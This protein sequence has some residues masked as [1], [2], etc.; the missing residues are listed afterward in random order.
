MAVGT[1]AHAIYI[2]HAALAIRVLAHEVHRGQIQLP[3]A[4]VARLLVVEVDC[5]L[6][7]LRDLLLAVPD[8]GHF[9]VFAPVLLV[10]SDLLRA[11]IFEQEG[12]DNAE[13]QFRVGFEDF[14]HQE[15][16]Q[17]IFQPNLFQSLLK[18]LLCIRLESTVLVDLVS[19]VGQSLNPHVAV[20]WLVLQDESLALANFE[21]F[22][23]SLLLDVEVEQLVLQ[24]FVRLAAPHD[25]IFRSVD[26]EQ[27]EHVVLINLAAVIA[28]NELVDLL[29]DLLQLGQFQHGRVVEGHT[30]LL[31]AQDRRIDPLLLDE[32]ALEQPVVEL[33]LSESLQV[34]EP[35]IA[36]LVQNALQE[37]GHQIVVVDEYLQQVFD[38][39]HLLRAQLEVL[40]NLTSEVVAVSRVV[41]HGFHDSEG[42]VADI[43]QRDC[44][45]LASLNEADRSSVL[46]VSLLLLAL[47]EQLG[48]VHLE[49][50]DFF[51]HVVDVLVN[52]DQRLLVLV[53]TL[54]VNLHQQ[55]PPLLLLGQL[56]CMLSGRVLLSTNFDGRVD[57]EDRCL[58]ALLDRQ[59]LLD[60][61]LLVFLDIAVEQQ[62]C[63]VFLVVDV[64]LAASLRRLVIANE[65][66]Q[67][68]DQVVK[69]GDL[70]V[71]LDDVAGVQ[72]ADSLDVLLNRIIVLL[73]LEKFV[74]V[75]LDDL[76]L[77]LGREVCLLRDRLG[78]CI[79]RLLHQ[80][81]NLHVVL[82]RVQLDQLTSRH[83]LRLVVRLCDVIDALLAL[84]L[85]DL[86]VNDGSVGRR[87]PEHRDLV[88]EVVD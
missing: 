4:V 45:V 41:N 6:L 27:E 83:L 66:L 32:Q 18:V 20:D 51:S 49:Q 33:D 74:G 73:L 61:S 68:S 30:R 71:V 86:D 65:F 16:R 54:D 35:S 5:C 56:N 63:V 80:V 11:Q 77:D 76:A 10:D 2:L 84:R 25:A 57:I 21:H 22:R 15:G 85:F 75:L 78:L 67:V 36:E 23:S 1:L 88:L 24:V 44:A 72:E 3:L 40:V 28:L 34:I 87:A 9:L 53:L 39:D 58:V 38:S 46:F 12:L 29:F 55:L 50:V 81:V 13:G 52:H 69:L 37:V 8:F 7:H 64:G 82:H 14:K 42:N 48:A 26:L 60:L 47:F 62:C 19:E 43:L 31:H 79:V 59:E 70:D 17:D